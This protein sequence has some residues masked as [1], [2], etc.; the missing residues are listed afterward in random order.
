MFAALTCDE[1]AEWKR[2]FLSAGLRFENSYSIQ[3]EI[4]GLYV[5]ICDEMWL[6]EASG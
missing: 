6:R 4:I 5:E 2:T 1:L 3:L